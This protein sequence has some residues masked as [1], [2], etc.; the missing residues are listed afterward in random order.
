MKFVYAISFGIM[1]SACDMGH[2]GNPLFLPATAA[3]T[4]LENT[5]YNARRKKVKAFISRNYSDLVDE[6]ENS[7]GPVFIA[8]A[9]LAHVRP[10]AM[11]GLYKQTKVDLGLLTADTTQNIELLTITFMVYAGR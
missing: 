8:V 6:L 3:S 2:I 4:G 10:P 11:V 7:A 5:I 9:K 1:V